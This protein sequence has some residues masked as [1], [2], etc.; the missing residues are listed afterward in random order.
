MRRI[1]GTALEW[2]GFAIFLLA[3]VGF[4]ASEAYGDA[5]GFG[6]LLVGMGVG[7]IGARI[8]ARCSSYA[9]ATWRCNAEPRRGRNS[10]DGRGQVRYRKQRE[11]KEQAA[12]LNA[13]GEYTEYRVQRRV[14]GW[15]VYDSNFDNHWAVNFMILLLA[16]PVIVAIWGGML[17]DSLIAPLLN[18]TGGTLHA[19]GSWVVIARRASSTACQQ[20]RVEHRVSLTLVH[21]DVTRARAQGGRTCSR[22]CVPAPPTT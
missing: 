21:R 1:V 11:A 14:R 13:A 3:A 18:D 12:A 20:Y 6:G 8:K 10:P 17:Y 2:V 4:V 16:L 7:V 15:Q 22:D 9:R 19:L 5:I